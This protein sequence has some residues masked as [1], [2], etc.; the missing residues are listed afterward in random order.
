MTQ[1]KEEEEN[2]TGYMVLQFNIWRICVIFSL[3]SHLKILSAI[4]ERER[5]GQYT[6]QQKDEEDTHT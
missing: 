2:N 3:S 1:K 4:R 6:S 5:Y